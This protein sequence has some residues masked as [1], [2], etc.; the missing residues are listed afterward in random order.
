MKPWWDELREKHKGKSIG[1]AGGILLGIVYLISGFWD[2]LFFLL[3][4]LIGYYIGSKADRGEIMEDVYKL[5]RWLTDRWNPF[6]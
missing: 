6:R 4:V 3:L 2:M 1:V 5:Y